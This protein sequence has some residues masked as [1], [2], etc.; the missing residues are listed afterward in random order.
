MRLNDTLVAHIIGTLWVVWIIYWIISAFNNKKTIYRQSQWFRL[1]FLIVLIAVFYT[2]DRYEN[3]DKVLFREMLFTQLLGI[4]LCAGGLAIAVWARIV[5]GRNWSGTPTIKEN[6]ELIQSGPYAIVRHPIYFGLIIAF[7]GTAL[8][9]IPTPAGVLDMAVVIVALF[10]KSR[11]EEKLMMQQ[12]PEAY[13]QYK[14]RVT[15]GLLPF[16]L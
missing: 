7:L 16:V 1:P 11:M 15:G 6:H 14:Q 13:P 2:L 5:L 9:T 10:I 8:A 12:F 4:A 3:L